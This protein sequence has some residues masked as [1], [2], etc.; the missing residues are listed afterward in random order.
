MDK[1][2]IYQPGLLWAKTENWIRAQ[3]PERELHQTDLTLVVYRTDKTGGYIMHG[4]KLYWSDEPLGGQYF[5]NC[6][7]S[8]LMDNTQVLGEVVLYDRRFRRTHLLGNTYAEA[9]EK[10]SK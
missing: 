2:R 6:D 9:W 1:E 7:Q 10:L 3:E 8:E 5:T 4:P